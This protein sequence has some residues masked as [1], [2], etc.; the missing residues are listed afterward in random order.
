M[1]DYSRII[2]FFLTPLI[3]RYHLPL[4]SYYCRKLFFFLQRRTILY[5]YLLSLQ[6]TNELA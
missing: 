4:G 1:P 3:F 2:V 5:R 6:N